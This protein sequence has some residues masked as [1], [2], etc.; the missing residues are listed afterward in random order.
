M[1]R[2]LATILILYVSLNSSAQKA[3]VDTLF[4]PIKGIEGYNPQEKLKFPIIKTGN[5]KIDAVINADLKNRVTNNEFATLS[6]R[7]ALVKWA[8]E[9]IVYLSFN[10]TY[11]NNSLISLCISIEGCG[12]YCS[13]WR[14]YYTYNISTG[15][16]LAIN[17]VIDTKGAFLKFVIANKNKQYEQQKKE[18]KEML[19]DKDA[20][21]DNELYSHVLERYENCRKQFEL[22]TFILHADHF[23]IIENCEMPHAIR[24]LTPIIKLKYAYADIKK[25][26]KIKY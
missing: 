8:E 9:S 17:D 16:L 4:F 19:N 20:K 1:T 24:N 23:E 2:T 15:K 11:N 13:I 18:L 14:E 6:T 7:E 21:L 25:Y 22:N 10:I 12:S 5:L 3:Q 26:L